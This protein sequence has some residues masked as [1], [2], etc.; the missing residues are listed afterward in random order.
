MRVEL[1]SLCIRVEARGQVAKIVF[2]GTIRTG[3]LVHLKVREQS[4]P[5]A[6]EFEHAAAAYRTVVE[7]RLHPRF[8]LRSRTGGPLPVLLNLSIAQMLSLLVHC[9]PSPMMNV[10][11]AFHPF[12]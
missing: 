11:S 8:C 5:G 3:C 12:N 9:T 10:E 4:E 1:G 2:A 7:V 6:L